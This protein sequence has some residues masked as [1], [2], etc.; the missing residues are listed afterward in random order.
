[1][2]KPLSQEEFIAL[3]EIAK[4]RRQVMVNMFSGTQLKF[5]TLASL[6]A[7]KSL[8]GSGKKV[9]GGTKKLASGAESAA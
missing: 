2:P 4:T 6:Q 5:G 8:F 9:H 7:G 3:A 1:M